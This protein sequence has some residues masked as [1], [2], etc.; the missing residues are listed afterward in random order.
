MT[1]NM[2]QLNETNL[3]HQS[4]QR[5]AERQFNVPNIPY[6]PDNL[7]QFTNTNHYTPYNIQQPPQQSYIPRMEQ[8]E[9]QR[10]IDKNTM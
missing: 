3:N 2:Y 5:I 8:P 10:K 9:L 4:S 7:K 6:N 1:P